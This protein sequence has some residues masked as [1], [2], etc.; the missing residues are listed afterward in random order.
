LFKNIVKRKKNWS[1]RLGVAGVETAS[2]NGGCSA[3][4]PQTKVPTPL[5]ASI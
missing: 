3:N 4:A 1:P 5:P 2:L